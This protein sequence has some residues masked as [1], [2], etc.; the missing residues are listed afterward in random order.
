MDF[1]VDPRNPGSHLKQSDYW[2]YMFPYYDISQRRNWNTVHNAGV[3]W[4]S[5]CQMNL[6]VLGLFMKASCIQD[7]VSLPKGNPW[8]CVA[9]Q[10]M[11]CY[12]SSKVGQAIF[13]PL[14]RE[15]GYSAYCKRVLV[16][17]KQHA[18]NGFQEAAK[19]EDSDGLHF[20]N[21]ALCR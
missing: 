14:A 15:V 8:T 17:T 3:T 16:F 6:S 12:T 19:Y 20:G 18:D 2:N 10:I 9:P 7:I 13:F 5:Y 1:K 4:S 21:G 11:H